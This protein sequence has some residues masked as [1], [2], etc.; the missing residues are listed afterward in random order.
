MFLCITRER[1]CNSKGCKA[2][3]ERKTIDSEDCAFD[4]FT[5]FP[6]LQPPFIDGDDPDL[7]H[8]YELVNDIHWRNHW[9]NS[10]SKSDIPPDFY[11]D[12]YQLMMEFMIVD[13]HTHTDS[14]GLINHQKRNDAKAYNELERA[15]NPDVFDKIKR[16]IVN[17]ITDSS[18]DDCNYTNYVEEFKRVVSKHLEKIPL[19]RK[20]HP[21]HKLIF[22][23]QDESTGYNE[24]E[25]E[26]H[27]DYNNHEPTYGFPH[28][29]FLDEEM[30]SIFKNTDVDYVVWWMPYRAGSDLPTIAVLNPG[31]LNHTIK[32]RSE[33]MLSSEDR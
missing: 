26:Y 15:M 7:F 25:Q 27:Q 2:M 9:I 28:L 13:D 23:I 8:V 12:E 4:F 5:D 11:S 24:V 14:Q 32:Y 33:L 16:V 19:Y 3:S 21:N 10:S 20:N 31:Q 30:V 22:F 6:H 18:D 1:K 17:T 29:P